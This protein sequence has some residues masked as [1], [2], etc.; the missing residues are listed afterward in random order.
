L[1]RRLSRHVTY[2][3]V[4][5]TLALFV[6]LGGTAAATTKAFIV[7]SNAD[8]APNTISGAKPPAG[9]HGNI[10]A[11]SIAAV[12]LATG[13]VQTS[14]IALDSV[15]GPKVKDG[16]LTGADLAADTVTGAQI[17]ESTLGTVPGATN[18]S[19]ASYASNAGALGGYAAGAYQR[20]VYGTCGSGSAI[21]TVASNGSVTCNYNHLR[22]GIANLNMGG[23]T[24]GAHSCAKI[25]IPLGGVAV[26]DSAIFVPDAAAWPAGLIFQTLRSD[27]TNKIAIDVCNPTNAQVASGSVAISIWVAKI[28]P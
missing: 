7:N 20:A 22:P 21:G 18:A 10:L 6:G 25:E 26:G 16:S 28:T 9:D 5:A 17:D 3:N 24:L 27:Q 14:K 2:A 23:I 11:G 13:A 15:T 1:I 4:A 12:D 19:T 8:V